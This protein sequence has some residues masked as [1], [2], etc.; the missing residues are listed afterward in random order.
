MKTEANMNSMLKHKIKEEGFKYDVLKGQLK[1]GSTISKEIHPVR[2]VEIL[3][4]ELHKKHFLKDAGN[5]YELKKPLYTGVL[6]ARNLHCGKLIKENDLR[7]NICFTHNERDKVTCDLYTGNIIS[8]D[9]DIVKITQKHNYKLKNIY[10][11]DVDKS[12]LQNHSSNG[13]GKDEEY[14]LK[15]LQERGIVSKN[16]RHGNANLNEADIVDEI[17][18]SQYE[19]IYE[20]KLQPAK[21]KNLSKILFDPKIQTMRLIS[22]NPFCITSKALENKFKHKKYSSKY[23]TYLVIL[24]IG[25]YK[26]TIDLIGKIAKMLEGESFELPFIDIIILSYDFLNETTTFV[27][28]KENEFD[29]RKY[30]DV[31]FDFINKKKVSV[32][33]L[34]E[35]VVYTIQC[36][37]IFDNKEMIFNG[38]MDEI[39][40]MIKELKIFL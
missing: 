34:K 12:F 28:A 16:A 11:I 35:N 2:E 22:D 39:K 32:S 21:K 17:N 10:S 38:S 4:K 25:T 18:K 1:K 36:T 29:E 19:I 20:S 9:S 24:N 14:V 13:F 26:T 8:S 30:K 37:G 6:M 3:K 33:D 40:N 27:Q 15:I 23:K 7:Q 31:N 5:V